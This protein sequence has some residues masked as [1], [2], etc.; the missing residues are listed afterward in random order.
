M[1]K[2][3]LLGGAGAA[4]AVVG[5]FAFAHHGAGSG[6]AQT[7]A[8]PPIPVV[9]VP[10]QTGTFPIE[11]KGLGTVQA[12]N[13]VTIHT[14]VDGQIQSINF[15]EGQKVAV[16]DTLLQIDPR[17]YQAQ[18]DQAVAAKARDEAQL[19]NAELN[20]KRDAQLVKPGYTTIQTFDTDKALVQQLE[21]TV[22]NGAAQIEYARVQLGYT[23]ITSPIPGAAGIRLVDVGNIVH[24]TD[25]SGIVVVTQTEPISVVFTLPEKAISDVRQHMANGPLKVLASSED[26]R[27]ELGEGQLQALDNQVDPQSGMVRLKATF[28]NKDDRLW[29]GEFVNARLVLDDK[30]DALTVPLAAVQQGAN[31]M[32]AY[33]VKPDLTVEQRPVET[34]ASERGR[35]LITKGLEPGDRVVVQGQSRLEPGA[36]VM[37][38][39]AEISSADVQS[40][41]AP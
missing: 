15:A 40:E 20:F 23:T 21:A 25:T 27:I 11:L 8:Q 14:R 10:V 41:S 26:D 36:H 29:P 16:G 39:P 37:I 28:P 4:C 6:A 7:A 30:A 12:L 2:P 19:A 9:A 34:D 22:Q 38:Q 13:T 24:A 35:A 3:F 31:G 32:F 1:T 33:V 5:W 17:P 18:L